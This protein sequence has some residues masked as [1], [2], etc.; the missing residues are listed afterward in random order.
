MLTAAGSSL[1]SDLTAAHEPD[2]CTVYLC[3]C[4][5]ELNGRVNDG[6]DP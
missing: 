5:S 1:C 2:V 3:V 6:F 4:R